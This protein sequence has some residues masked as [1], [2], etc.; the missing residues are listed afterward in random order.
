M[1]RHRLVCGVNTNTVQKR[2]LAESRL[3]FEDALKI[4]TSME[5]VTAKAQEFMRESQDRLAVHRVGT[6]MTVA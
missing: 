5:A 4:A 1:L 6:P 2:L 3:T